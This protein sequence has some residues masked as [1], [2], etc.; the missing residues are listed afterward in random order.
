MRISEMNMVTPCFVF[1][2]NGIYGEAQKTDEENDDELESEDDILYE[3][4]VHDGV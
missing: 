4:S 1:V 2:A 3:R